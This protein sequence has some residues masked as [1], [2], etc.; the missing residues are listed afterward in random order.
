MSEVIKAQFRIALGSSTQDPKTSVY[1][2]TSIRLPDRDEIFM[3]SAASS[4]LSLH[5]ELSALPAVKKATK[6]IQV[7]GQYRRVNVSLRDSLRNVY[8]DEDE[9]VIFGEE[10]LEEGSV[11]ADGEPITCSINEPKKKS[12]QSITKDMICSKFTGKDLD[13][14][15]WLR[16]FDK[17]CE[18][19]DIPQNQRV[20]ALRLFLDGTPAAWFES[21][22]TLIGV[23]TWEHWTAMFLESFGGKSWSDVWYAVQY[24]WMK[25]GTYSEFVIKKYG[26]LISAFPDMSEQDRI[27]LVI[28]GL[29]PSVSE[30]LDRNEINTQG[31]LLS[32]LNMLSIGGKGNKF[33]NN[34]AKFS[35]FEKGSNSESINKYNSSSFSTQGN[36][37]CQICEKLGYKNRFHPEDKCRNRS[38]A[39]ENKFKER[40]VK[41]AHNTE[42]EQLFNEEAKNS[43]N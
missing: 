8:L 27:A 2:V 12:M 34:N 42:L 13:A 41:I 9:N 40:N 23:S 37:P 20:E 16:S 11:Q 35:G 33:K 5:K 14:N 39:S 43:K 36:K 3:F 4:P 21:N 19:L 17:E 15:V 30:K 22:W 25:N 6:S 32:K 28:I 7:R 18:R 29:P 26:L 10:F 1:L 38:G 24:K 31:K